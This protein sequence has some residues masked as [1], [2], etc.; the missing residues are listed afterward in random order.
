MLALTR[1]HMAVPNYQYSK[2]YLLVQLQAKLYRHRSIWQQT[3]NAS[4]EQYDEK[5]SVE[6]N[7]AGGA[8]LKSRKN[9]AN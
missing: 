6:H 5:T 9:E 7:R 4:C 8:N 2:Q 3:S 1:A